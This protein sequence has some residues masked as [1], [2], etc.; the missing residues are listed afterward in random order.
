MKQLEGNKI[1]GKKQKFKNRYSK[2]HVLF[3]R[4]AEERGASKE[5]V[6]TATFKVK[7]FWKD[8]FGVSSLIEL[9]DKELHNLEILVEERIRSIQI[10]KN[11]GS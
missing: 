5:H 1:L 4:L 6:G 7:K 2:I 11:N 3:R 10:N 8:F 9:K